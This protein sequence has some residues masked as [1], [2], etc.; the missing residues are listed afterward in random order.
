[1]SDLQSYSHARFSPNITGFNVLKRRCGNICVGSS[2]VRDEN[3]VGEFCK[4]EYL[5]MFKAFFKK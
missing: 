1:M 5:V 2:I 4:G 3:I